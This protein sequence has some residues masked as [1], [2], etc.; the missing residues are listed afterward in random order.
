LAT[1]VLFVQIV[2]MQP[3]IIRAATMGAIGAWAL[4]YGRGSQVL[5]ILA[6]S[7]IV[8]LTMSPELIHEVVFQLSVAATAGIVL[9]AQ[10]L[11]AW[12]RPMLEKV[13]P[14]FWAT[15]LSSS[16]AISATAQLACQPLLL[17]FIDYVSPYSLLANLLATPLLPMITI[18]GTVAAGLGIVAPGIAQLLLH[19]VSLPTAAIGWIATSVTNLPGAMLPWPEGLAGTVLIVLHWTA[20]CIVLLKLLRRQRHSKPAVKIDSPQA[21]WFGVLTAAVQRLTM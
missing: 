1:L 15:M 4:F 14:N 8:I 7:T 19:V 12:C 21:G 17:T 6:L 20:S 3:S 9:G 11:E 2:G 16:F 18:P 10:P 13:L 5:P